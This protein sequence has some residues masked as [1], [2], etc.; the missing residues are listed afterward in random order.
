MQITAQTLYCHGGTQ[1]IEYICAANKDRNFLE[2]TTCSTEL[3][4]FLNCQFSNHIFAEIWLILRNFR[5]IKIIFFYFVSWRMSAFWRR[6]K[7]PWQ[8]T[9]DV[10]ML[11]HLYRD[12]GEEKVEMKVRGRIL[13]ILYFIEMGRKRRVRGRCGEVY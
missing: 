12:G 10:C 13:I 6:L 11:L 7:E 3:N 9:F 8:P 2:K 1:Q 4:L 5:S